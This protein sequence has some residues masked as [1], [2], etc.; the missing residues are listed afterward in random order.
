MHTVTGPYDSYG[1]MGNENDATTSVTVNDGQIATPIVSYQPFTGVLDVAVPSTSSN[2]ITPDVSVT[3]FP[4]SGGT[5]NYGT[6]ITTFGLTTLEGLTPESCLVGATQQT[7]SHYTYDPVLTPAGG[8]VDVTAGNA[9]FVT[10]DYQPIDGAISVSISGPIPSSA[11]Y[12]ATIAD[13]GSYSNTV[14]GNT[15]VPYVSAAAYTVTAPLY[16]TYGTICV[17]HNGTSFD[18]YTPTVTPSSF[19]LAKGAT[20]AVAVSYVHTTVQCSNGP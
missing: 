18:K 1:L 13:G 2:A 12:N 17:L 11:S 6:F 10:V 9:T 8:S 19:T 5:P 14:Y 15:L 20:Q 7:D 16:S 4:S 3:G